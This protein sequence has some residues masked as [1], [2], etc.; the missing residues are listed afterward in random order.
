MADDGKVADVFGWKSFHRWS[1][2]CMWCGAQA[3]KQKNL[4]RPVLVSAE[5]A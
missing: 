3:S 5:R 1:N 4:K 2:A